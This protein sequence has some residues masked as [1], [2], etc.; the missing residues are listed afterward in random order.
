MLKTEPFLL[1]LIHWRLT[2]DRRIVK[3]GVDLY[4]S[5]GLSAYRVGERLGQQLQTTPEGLK[6]MI[7]DNQLT[8]IKKQ[9]QLPNSLG[10]RALLD[11][12]RKEIILF[13]PVLNQIEKHLPWTAGHLVP[14]ALAHEYFHYLQTTGKVEFLC[15]R[16]PLGKRW[17]FFPIR[18]QVF[19]EIAASGFAQ[20][21]LQLPYSPLA[22]DY[23]MAERK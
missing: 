15:N 14:I 21:I 20:G 17:G 19:D 11:T 8:I 4:L 16:W 3:R 10:V 9:V 5:T 13:L 12:E 1:D 18:T 7:K 23:F 6:S 22:I 2:L